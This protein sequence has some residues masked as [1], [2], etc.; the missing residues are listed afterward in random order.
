MS[1]VHVRDLPDDVLEALKRRAARHHR[2]LQKE[3]RLILIEAAEE[4]PPAE[5]VPPIRLAM[6]RAEPQGSWRREDIYDDDGR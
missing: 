6:S 5:P 2:S 1:A 3:L 4:A